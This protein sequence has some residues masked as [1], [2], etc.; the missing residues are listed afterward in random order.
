MIQ[1]PNIP[2]RVALI[3]ALSSATGLPVW[4]KKVPKNV[5]PI[6]TSYIL[7]QSQSKQRTAISKN[8]WEWDSTINIDITYI[9]QQGFSNTVPIDNAEEQAINVIEDLEIPGWFVK[10]IHLIGSS[11]LDDETDTQTVERRILIYNFWLWPM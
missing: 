7:L 8:C 6:P 10:N 3:A 5:K 1:N 9:N 4:H 11:D 2:V